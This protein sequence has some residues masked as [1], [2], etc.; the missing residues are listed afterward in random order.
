MEDVNGV[1]I[2]NDAAPLLYVALFMSSSVM[3]LP[4]SLL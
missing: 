1:D 4:K 2:D 3:G